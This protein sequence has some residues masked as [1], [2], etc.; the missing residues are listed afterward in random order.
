MYVE[1]P[2]PAVYD[3]YSEI[4]ILGSFPSVKSREN[5]FFYGHSQNRFWK[6]IAAIFGDNVP[7]TI[8]DKR[9]LLLKNHIALWD[10]IKSCEI[11]GS[12]DNSITHVTPNDLSPILNKTQ[13]HKIIVNGKIAEKYYK[14]YIEPQ[15]HRIAIYLPSTS[16]ANAS[17]NLERLV[18]VWWNFIKT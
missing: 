16:S 9:N 7:K 1:H 4:L 13:I 5:S 10:V 12:Y 11:K 18:S 8:L 6:V 14:K 17:W 2:F 15:I 3:E